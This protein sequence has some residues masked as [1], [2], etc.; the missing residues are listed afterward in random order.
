MNRQQPSTLCPTPTA[1]VQADICQL[2]LDQRKVNVLAR[3]YCD[4][5]KRKFKPVVLSHAMVPGL[6]QG[7]EKMSKSDP[8]SAIFMEDSEADVRTKIK[9]ARTRSR[10]GVRVWRAAGGGTRPDRRPTPP[11]PATP[12]PPPPTL[13][14]PATDYAQAY[15]PPVVVDGNPCL[16]YIRLIVLPWHGVFEVPLSE[17]SGGG[18][19]AYAEF[20]DLA[21]DYAA[22]D[23][24]PGDIKPA[25]AAALNAI[26]DPVRK[27]F[28]ADPAAADLLKKVR[29]YKVTK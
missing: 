2:G 1:P 10:G 13:P 19:R 12:P 25:L 26:L 20:K 11:A 9:K 5:I 16:E 27:H 28:E 7:Q 4:S 15:C 18:V 17:K 21:A 23:L 6:L 29:S 3:E 24:H 8:G 22:G 14:T